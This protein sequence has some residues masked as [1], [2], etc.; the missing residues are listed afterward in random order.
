L[1]Q[2]QQEGRK[3][4]RQKIPE[5]LHVL[6]SGLGLEAKKGLVSKNSKNKTPTRGVFGQ[7]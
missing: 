2:G 7:N 6:H 5:R 4:G 1:D 3:E